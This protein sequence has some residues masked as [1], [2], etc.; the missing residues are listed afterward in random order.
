M[1]N[2]ESYWI[3]DQRGK[4][5]NVESDISY[6]FLCILSHWL[7]LYYSFK[8][9]KFLVYDSVMLELSVCRSGVSPASCPKGTGVL[10]QG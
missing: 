7:P 9:N 1:K 6:V 10:S 4:I 2:V 8:T 3:G 5:L